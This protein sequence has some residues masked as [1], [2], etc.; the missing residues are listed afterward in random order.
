MFGSQIN[1]WHISNRMFYGHWNRC[2]SSN[3]MF[4]KWN[5]ITHTWWVSLE[6]TS[7]GM[8]AIDQL[9]WN[10]RLK[11]ILQNS[12]EMCYR[13]VVRSNISFSIVCIKHT[14]I[15][16]TGA[17]YPPPLLCPWPPAWPP[18]VNRTKI[19][20]SLM[21]F[22]IH[23]MHCNHRLWLEEKRVICS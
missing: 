23:K 21:S 20:H 11:F 6:I 19:Y 22:W 15:T 13:C 7:M 4:W 9:Q 16:L 17:E 14:L 8:S 10:H 18:P 3:Q 12:S 5:E 1:K 2:R